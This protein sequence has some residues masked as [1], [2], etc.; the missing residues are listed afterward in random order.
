[1]QEMRIDTE[2]RKRVKFTAEELPD[3]IVSVAE[4]HDGTTLKM[5]QLNSGEINV[6][7][8]KTLV[9]QADGYTVTIV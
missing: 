7:C 1:M 5:T 2:G 6:E 4:Y 8:N 9:L 3:K